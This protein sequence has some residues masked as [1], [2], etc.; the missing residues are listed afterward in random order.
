LAS[1]SDIAVIVA[2]PKT[3]RNRMIRRKKLLWARFI[4]AF[5]KAGLQIRDGGDSA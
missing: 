3:L 2:G 5:F 4:K 1:L